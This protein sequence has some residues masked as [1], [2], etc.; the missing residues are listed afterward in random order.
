M[1]SH[2]IDFTPLVKLYGWK[3]VIDQLGSLLINDNVIIEMNEKHQQH[4]VPKVIQ[5]H[6]QY[7]GNCN[8]FLGANQVH[9]ITFTDEGI[10]YVF[11]SEQPPFLS[12]PFSSVV[13]EKNA[14]IL[15]YSE[16][17]EVTLLTEKNAATGLDYN[18]II[19]AAGSTEHSTHKCLAKSSHIF[20]YDK[21]MEDELFSLLMEKKIKVKFHLE[22]IKKKELEKSKNKD[23]KRKRRLFFRST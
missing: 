10:K 16:A 13:D 6:A 21:N 11:K 7:F 17:S 3:D 14:Y 15:P 22:V 23:A 20:D 2:K 9:D 5:L 1:K 4:P 12:E 18:E 19:V 8:I